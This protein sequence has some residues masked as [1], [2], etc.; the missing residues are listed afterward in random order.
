MHVLGRS[1]AVNSSVTKREKTQGAANQVHCFTNSLAY[2]PCPCGH[3]IGN[4][5]VPEEGVVDE[6][7]LLGAPEVSFNW[8]LPAHNVR[9]RLSSHALGS[10]NCFLPTLSVVVTTADTFKLRLAAMAVVAQRLCVCFNAV[11]S[12]FP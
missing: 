8:L 4:E 10:C 11:L 7:S 5:S 6:E 12:T 3:A 2:C 9:H 1:N